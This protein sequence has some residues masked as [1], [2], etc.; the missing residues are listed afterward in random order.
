MSMQIQISSFLRFSSSSASLLSFN[1][2]SINP[3]YRHPSPSVLAISSTLSAARIPFTDVFA[4][5]ISRIGALKKDGL[6]SPVSCSTEYTFCST[7]CHTYCPGRFLSFFSQIAAIPAIYMVSLLEVFY[8][9]RYK[10][11]PAHFLL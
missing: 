8:S 4:A 11:H 2:L 3:E 6:L 5:T 7:D 10:L 1:P 9:L